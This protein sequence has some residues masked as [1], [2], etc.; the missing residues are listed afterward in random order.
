LGVAGSFRDSAKN[1]GE[2]VED[3]GGFEVF[4]K[5]RDEVRMNL[6][7]ILPDLGQVADVNPSPNGH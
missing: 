6:S 2:S 1:S 4:A 5:D 3:D 7:K